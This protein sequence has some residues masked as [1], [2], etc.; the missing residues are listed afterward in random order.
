[1]RTGKRRLLRA[2]GASEAD[3]TGGE[4]AKLSCVRTNQQIPSGI[5]SAGR[6]LDA[7]VA[8]NR[9]DALPVKAIRFFPK[10][11]EL[12][13]VRPG[14]KIG[15]GIFDCEQELRTDPMDVEGLSALSLQ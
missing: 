12:F 14:K 6:P 7:F 1:M 3:I 11:S 4:S 13:R 8:V 5:N 15:V 2:G 10:Q 9:N